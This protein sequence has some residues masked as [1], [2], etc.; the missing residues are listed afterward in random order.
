MCKS[1]EELAWKPYTW[2]N[3]VYGKLNLKIT[4]KMSARLKVMTESHS[5]GDKHDP[6]GVQRNSKAIT[7]K[8][9]SHLR[10]ADITKL[11]HYC[12]EAIDYRTYETT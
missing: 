11:Q 4:S 6:W 8:W 1:Y 5:L 9:K 10:W 7:S 12:K 2:A 3:K